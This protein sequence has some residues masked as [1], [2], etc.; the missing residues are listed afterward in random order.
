MNTLT[1]FL[2]KNMKKNF[3]Y[4]VLFGIGGLLWY[5][6]T[7]TTSSTKNQQSNNLVDR[8]TYQKKPRKPHPKDNLKADRPDLFAAYLRRLKTGADESFPSYPANYRM[9]ELQKAQSRNKPF[10]TESNNFKERGPGNVAGRT[11]ALVIDP[12]DPKKTWYAGSAGGG[13]WKTTNGGESWKHLTASLPTL[14]ISCLAIAPSNPNVLYAGTGEGFFSGGSGTGEGIFKTEDGGQVWTQLTST[15]NLDFSNV[16]RIIVDPNNENVLLAAAAPIPDNLVYAAETSKIYRSTDGGQSW[17]TVYESPYP[18]YQLIGQKGNFN[19]LYAGIREVGV[20]K[21]EDSGLTWNTSNNGIGQVGRVELAISENNPNIL[22][23]SAQGTVSEGSGDLYYSS[24]AGANWKLLTPSQDEPSIDLLGGQG[25]YDNTILI[26]P[27]NDSIVYVGGVGAYQIKLTNQPDTIIQSVLGTSLTNAD[28]FLREDIRMFTDEGRSIEPTD[29][30]GIE[31]RFGTDKSQKAYRFS[32]PEGRTSGVGAQDYTYQNMIDVPFEVWDTKNNR[33]LMVSIRDQLNDGAFDLKEQFNDSREYIFVH[34]IPY[35][36]TPDDSVTVTG[37][38]TYKNMYLIWVAQPSG[39][40]WNPSELPQATI[41]VG[42]GNVVTQ[43]RQ[44]VVIADQYGEL[45]EGHEAR[46]RNSGFFAGGVHADMHQLIALQGDIEGEFQILA[47]NDG[48]VYLS[49]LSNLPATQDSAWVS[50]GMTY[51]TSQFYGIAKIPNQQ[52]Y[53]G[54]TQDNGSWGFLNRNDSI[55]DAN[56]AYIALKGGDGFECQWHATRDTTFLMSSQFNSIDKFDPNTGWRNGRNGMTDVGEENAPFVSR[57]AYTK[58]DPDLV[59]TV[60]KSGVWRS[61]NFAD[62]WQL[63]PISKKWNHIGYPD[64]DVSRVNPRV[65]WA[66]AGMSKSNQIY[67]SKDG[68]LSFTTI[69]N[70]ADIGETSGIYTHPTEEGTAFVLFAASQK[71]KILRTKNFGE[72][73]EDISG[74]DSDSQSEGFPNVPVFSV[75]VMPHDT[76]RIWAGTEIG[77]MES[78][79]EGK[80]WHLINDFPSVSVWD[81]RFEDDEIVIGTHGRGIWTATIPELATVS[82][83]EVVLA[84]RLNIL[85]QVPKSEEIRLNLNM[86]LRSAYDSVQIWQ[87]NKWIGSIGE[88]VVSRPDFDFEF[89]APEDLDSLFVQAIAYRGGE[90]Y[91]SGSLSLTK[92]QVIQFSK[93]QTSYETT[94]DD[95]KTDFLNFGFRIGEEEQFTGVALHSLHP[96]L[97]GQAFGGEINYTA[98]LSVP[99]IVAEKNALISFEEVAL[100]EV[101]DANTIFGDNEFWDYV[102]VEGSTDFKTWKPLLNGYDANADADWLAAYNDGKWGDQ[103]L[104]RKR[105]VRLQNQFEAGETVF[106]RF[107]LFSDAASVGFGW[108]I[109]NLRIQTEELLTSLNAERILKAVSIYPNPSTD[110]GFNLTLDNVMDKNLTIKIYNNSGKLVHQEKVTQ[111]GILFN[112]RIQLQNQSKGLYIVEVS[113]GKERITKK[114]ILE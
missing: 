57:L 35:S 111:E 44:T 29:F 17:E 107:R 104:F 21:S 70:H 42:Y 18:I 5:E 54:G 11:R 31:I 108:V 79:D 76:Q 9:I 80:T 1:I 26:H 41:K 100:V 64:I 65:V 32:V 12:Q 69:E 40:K 59:F 91:K 52:Q 33:Q 110:G 102:I 77:I 95:G 67:L 13:I 74:F 47:S 39:I 71:P 81:M 93:P 14:S 82:T 30:V 96:Y 22:Y 2:I 20:L 3:L 84:P 15:A 85:T 48:G 86:D 99:I 49:N 112:H 23:A 94:F 28:R 75:L 66:G 51:N 24:D 34:A 38:H 46:Y 58:T 72:T 105:F 113:D 53:I 43:P 19:V 6:T 73:W 37:G 60:G 103:S 90:I 25:E 88:N 63:T 98:L 68:G 78:T 7:H 4:L 55:A 83:P 8:L 16:S 56:D 36:E 97:E 45:P 27:F 50:L 61:D 87:N 101:G 62:S 89:S 10:R 106:L 92:D 109:D 114:L